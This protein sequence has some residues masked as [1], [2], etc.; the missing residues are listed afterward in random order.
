MVGKT[1][2]KYI[3]TNHLFRS[4]WRSMPLRHFS[5]EL[6]RNAWW[7]HRRVSGGNEPYRIVVISHKTHKLSSKTFQRCTHSDNDFTPVSRIVEV[8]WRWTCIL[9]V[10]FLFSGTLAD[11]TKFDS[12]RDR[13]EPFSFV[14]G[15]GQVIKGIIWSFF[16]GFRFRCY[17][18]YIFDEVNG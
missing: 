9:L 18:Q 15:R 12:S 16:H 13:G 7:T 2:W 11:G 10:F 17:I 3:R 6:L 4:S 5:E 8:L 1:D 14:L